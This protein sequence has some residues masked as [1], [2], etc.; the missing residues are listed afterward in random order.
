MGDIMSDVRELKVPFF[1]RKQ[2]TVGQTIYTRATCIFHVI[3]AYIKYMATATAGTR[4]VKCVLVD[5]NGYEL[6]LADNISVSENGIGEFILTNP[7]FIMAS[8]RFGLK[9][10]DENAVDDADTYEFVAIGYFHFGEAGYV[11]DFLV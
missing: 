4:N 1:V 6:K 3:R 2:K 8:S 10:E 11:L 5:P 7:F 9:V